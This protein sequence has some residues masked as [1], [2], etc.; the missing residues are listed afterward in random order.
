M[1]V[2]GLR[3][4]APYHWDGIPGDPYGG[5][6]T[7]SIWSSTEPNC[8]PEQPESCT[9]FL[10]DGSLRTTMCMVGNCL[11]NDEGKAG[12]LSAAE[13][14][15]LATF[16][17]SVP[18]PPSQRRS[19]TNVPSMR[20]RDGFKA[21]HVD[22]V[23][24]D[25]RANICGNCHRIPFWVST[26]TPGTGMDAPTW[27]GAYDRWLILPQGRWNVLDLRS[28]QEQ[29]R[30]FP[31]R[32][33]WGATQG[34]RAPFWDMVV[35]GSTGFSGSFGRQ[36]TLNQA[37][38]SLW[39]TTVRRETPPGGGPSPS[40]APISMQEDLF[41]AL[42]LS[43]VEGGI[44]LQGEGVFVD[45]DETRRTTLRYVDGN[46][47]ELGDDPRS[48]ARNDLV[49]LAARGSFVGTFTGRLGPNV[50]VDHPQPAIWSR[51]PIHEQRGRQLFPRLSDGNASMVISGRHIQEG[52][53]VIVDGRRIE[54]SVRCVNGAFPN[55]G[56]GSISIRLDT[57]PASEGVH[58]LQVQNPGGLFS[59]D[60]IIQN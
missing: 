50:D 13:R 43:A 14:D 23:Q 33:I 6:N 30:G 36:V 47:V 15:D 35:E 31:E 42:E 40:V 48:F 4:T 8:T 17:L 5:P 38:A 46:Y 52:A 29:D 51:G 1:P 34:D 49:A 2:R 24:E 60:F 57:L 22:G 58:L 19:Y 56:D 32:S 12:A 55:C 59:N 20:A 21:F 27:R 16:L 18:Y 37:F 9:R 41:R 11:V 7:A 10:V 3:D 28:Q 45:G 53:Y 25:G 26:N 54:G 44:V 39:L